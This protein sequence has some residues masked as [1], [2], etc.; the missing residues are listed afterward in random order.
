MLKKLGIFGGAF[1]PVHQGHIHIAK[2]AY[3]E[4][5]LDKVYFLP[6]N[7]AVHKNQ[8]QFS[9]E[10]RLELIRQAIAPY[11]YL[12]I[13]RYDIERGGPSYAADTLAELKKQPDFTDADLYYII[14]SDAFAE[15]FTWKDPYRL[16][17]LVKFIVA[18]RPGY[19]FSRIEKVFSGQKKYLDRLFLLEDAGVAMSSS[20]IRRLRY[21]P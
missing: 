20:Q 4:L 7:Q 21:D 18:A 17:D 12:D 19:D 5:A 6:L 15:I 11:A 2:L 16:L 8:P 14:G 13:C 9:A 1:D 3:K 10:K